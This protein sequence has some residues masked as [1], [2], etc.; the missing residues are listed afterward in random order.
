MSDPDQP[1]GTLATRVMAMPA[2]TNPSGDI[3][4]GWLLGQMD[5]AGGSFSRRYAGCQTVT[6]ALDSM[7]FLRP[8]FVGDMVCC[9]CELVKVGKTSMAVKIEAWAVREYSSERIKVTEGVFS[10]VAIDRDRRPRSI[11]R[12]EMD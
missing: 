3:F 12:R 9:Y 6:V 1:K 2:D 4:G 5:S 8:V 10:Y 7:S 11:E